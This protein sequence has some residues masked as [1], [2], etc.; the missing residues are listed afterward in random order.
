M[1]VWT[2]FKIRSSPSGV[3]LRKACGNVLD[4]YTGGEFNVSRESDDFGFYSV[5]VCLDGFE[6]V[7]VI[8]KIIKY[9]K[10]RDSKCNVE[11]EVYHLQLR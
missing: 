4:R 3:S 9:C 11:V 8:H 7:E 2:H 6:T 5:S 1:S 10:E